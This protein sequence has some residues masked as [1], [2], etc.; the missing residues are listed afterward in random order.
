MEAKQSAEPEISRDALKREI[1]VASLGIL[2]LM[3]VVKH[4]GAVVPFIGR[5]SFT[6]AA[7]VQLY[8]PLLLLGKRGI[9]KD[10]LGLRLS[11]WREDLKVF[12]PLALLTIVPFGLGHHIWQTE[13][14]NR[15]FSF[16]WPPDFLESV[17]VQ[18]F[19]VALAEEIFYRGYLQ[20]RMQALWPAQRKLFGAP[21]GAAIIVSSAVFALAHFAGEYRP[22][23]LG[24]FFPSLLFG[25]LRARTGS[26]LGAM[27]YH[28]FC[29]LL[30]DV[31]FASYSR[32]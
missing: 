30:A 7:A 1:L 23:R 22:A 18:F 14:F 11:G 13:L 15:S 9:T 24:P 27:S 8:V 16:R 21:F 19:V 2:A 29:N 25:L 12:V 4:L 17:L 32:G 26:I 6:I 20:G 28:A 5:H 3:T 10:V 31:L